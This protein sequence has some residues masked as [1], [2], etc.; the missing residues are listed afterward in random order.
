MSRK[1]L[2]TAPLRRSRCTP[3]VR[4]GPLADWTGDAR[5]FVPQGYESG[6]D[7]PLLVWLAEPG[8]RFDL[9]RAMTR[10]SLRNYVAVQPSGS[11]TAMWR[12]I[13]RVRDRLS[14]H[15]RRIWLIGQ[16][17]GGTE[18]LRAVCRHPDECA[19]GISL[20]GRFPL[21]ESALARLDE[22][23]RLPMLLC[24]RAADARRDASAL[25][26]RRRHARR[27]DLPARRAAVAG[28]PGRRQPLA[29]GG[30]QRSPVAAPA[31]RSPLEASHE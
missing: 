25:S 26:R 16:G 19:G 8:T 9:G 14:I 1:S 4:R 20:G 15:P 7:Y 31:A 5:V 12:A 17:S 24:C 18:A 3:D 13:D 22:I 27:A 6:Y 23:R 29:H 2:A 28:R 11:E 10:L 21:G 30:D